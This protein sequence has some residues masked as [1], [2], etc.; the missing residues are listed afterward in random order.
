MSTAITRARST[1][2]SARAGAPGKIANR[3]ARL[4]SARRMTERSISVSSIEA[5]SPASEPPAIGGR[6]HFSGAGAQRRGVEPERVLGLAQRRGAA[7]RIALV[8]AADL[9]QDGLELGRLAAP[10]K[11]VAAAPRA[12]L[13]ACGHE[14]LGVG[15]RA[16]DGADVAAVEHGAAG[17]CRKAPLQIEERVAHRLEGGDDRGGV[18]HLASAQALVVEALEVE[19]APDDRRGPDLGEGAAVVEERAGDRP[20][21]EAR[22]EMRQAVMRGKPS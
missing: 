12:L 10:A 7:G 16:D 17:L 5:M 20:V 18:A 9:G 19:L 1:S 11:L 13:R 15:I 14:Q 21:E 3:I 4:A 8:A 22:V 2:V 6:S